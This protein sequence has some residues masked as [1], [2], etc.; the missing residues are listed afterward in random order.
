[1]SPQSSQPSDRFAIESRVGGGASGDIFKA[2]D[3]ATGQTVALKVLRHTAS[4]MERARFEREVQVIAE[5]RHPNIV[6]YVSH[7]AR[8]DGRLFMA[9]EWL[10]GEDLA[11]RQRRA[12]LGTRDAV[13]VVRRAAQALAAIHA[14]GVVHRDLKLSNL[15]LVRGRGTAVKLIDFG[16]VK[17]AADD[18]FQTEAGTILGT[19]HYMA[20][21]Q[22]RGETVDPRADVYSLGSVLFR[23]L[24]GRNVFETEHVIALLGRLVLED[25]PR[26]SQFRFDIPEKLDAVVHRAISR[27]RE[28]RYEH[29]GEFARALARVGAVNNDPPE[30]E[31]SA[32]AVR[33]VTREDTQT[34]TGESR[35]TRP[36]M[37][38]R[39]VVACMLYDLGD[40]SI[41][42]SIG[43]SLLDIA[44]ED[45]RIEQLAGGKTVAVLG[46]EHSRGDEALRA[47]RAGLQML[48]EYPEARAV[49]AVGHAV[50]ARSNLA[51][52]ALDRAA[53]QLAIATPGVVRLDDH[54][55]AALERRFEISRDRQGAVLLREDPRDLGP[56]QVLGRVTPTVGREKE[57]AELQAL[58]HDM[59]RDSFPRAAL[60]LGPSGIGKSRVRS[61]LTQRLEM[62]PMPPEVL[63]CRGDSQD[64]GA[65]V[66]LL[67][68]TLR[69][70]MGVQDGADLDEQVAIVRRHVRAR[71]PRSLHFLAAFLGELVGV[72]FPD[73]G[74]EP[75]RAA[76]ANDQ[77]MQSRIR[78][79]LEAY[80][81]TQAGRIPQV[82]VIEE[83][84][85]ADDTTL[86]LVDWILGCPDIRIVAFAFAQ[87]ELLRRMPNLW[88]KAQV[89]RMTLSP[90]PPTMADRIVHAA[91]PD[92]SADQR[93]ELVQRA[94]G[95]PFVLEELIRCAA[96]G[97]SDLPLTVQ[98]LVQLRL[99][100]LAPGVHEVLRAA[101]IF[102]QCFWSGGVAALLDRD[103]IDDLDRAEREEIVIAQPTSRVAGE[104]ELIFRQ[105]LVRDAAHASLVDDDRKALHLA[106]GEW[107]E[108]SGS[109]DLGLIAGH[110]EAGGAL[111]RAAGLYARATQQAL[112]NFGRMDNALELAQ[113]GIACGA[114]GGERAQLL[115]TVAHVLSRRGEL[116]D[117]IAAAEEAATLVPEG[118]DMWVEAQRLL[119]A[120]LIE[121]GRALEGDS[122]LAWALGPPHGA[123]LSP[124][125][126]SVL[127]S[128]RVRGL[129]D[130]GR[131]DDALAI[132]EEAVSQARTAGSRGEAAMLRALDARVF[133][134]MMA[135]KADA[136]FTAAEALIEAA[137]RAGDVHLA[138][139][140]RINGA[141]SL[142]YLGLYEEARKLLDRALPDVRSF[143]LRILEA[144]CLHNIGM[145]LARQ[146]QLDQGIEMQRDASRIADAM[147]G[148]RLAINCR[149]YQALMLVWRGAPGD[150]R[151]ANALADAVTQATRAHPSLQPIAL[152]VMARVQLA[153]MHAEAAVTA[154]RS[155][156]QLMQTTALEEWEESA[157]LT[158]IDALQAV[159]AS[160]EADRA[161]AEAFAAVERRAQE[162]ARPEIRRSYLERNEEVARILAAAHHRLGLRLA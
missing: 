81:R 111:D 90:L 25:P 146:G 13:E 161:L 145:A 17:P 30:V 29:A 76:R 147:G 152:L 156:Y 33:P 130:L 133:G 134:L 63:L 9:M 149:I 39:R 42:R 119:G 10:E 45:A 34:G 136:A 97:G 93:A 18:A 144:S 118:S 40:T 36:G 160:E 98:A 72:P 46:V 31:R 127:L 16:V 141:S 132:A 58:Y 123:S 54:A 155:L 92:C 61:E 65:S 4:P 140:G 19:P 150:L 22:A 53:R 57:I 112:A 77:L 131:A 96:E 74:D 95:N 49:V 107:L 62:A 14:R 85:L 11:K 126:R 47:A 38:M 124:Q 78:M 23:L 20:P 115:N 135:C 26:P 138:S 50:Q 3:N 113:R 103:V 71:L 7:G 159:G 162:I 143:R 73:Q 66:S 109:V 129:V 15:F 120:C 91:L 21:E 24:T 5:L 68:R 12:P 83:A 28:A 125:L 106:A 104:R 99:D 52:E 69:A 117:A 2:I 108:A 137:D 48:E 70:Q 56:R 59:L 101:S 64:G 41:D 27:Q 75:L 128:A 148:I 89:T 88:S 102:G 100:R 37:R 32:S 51:G 60:V 157:R 110:F 79:A 116:S 158:H 122:R 94:A 55:A 142:N 82:I 121:A 80:V 84:H 35:P 6:E 8:P 153:R 154:A 43:D 86:D 105:A 139:R 114:T 151:E 67:G 44:G 87:P 1:M